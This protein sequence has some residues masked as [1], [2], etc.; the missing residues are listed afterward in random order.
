MQDD[1]LHVNSTKK[2]PKTTTSWCKMIHLMWTLQRRLPKQHTF[3][4]FDHLLHVNYIE[5]ATKVRPSRCKMIHF[6]WILLRKLHKSHLNIGWFIPCEPVE[7]V[8]KVTPSWWKTIHSTWILPK[9]IPKWYILGAG[10]L[11]HVNPSK[12]L[13]KQNF[14]KMM[15]SVWTLLRRLSKSHLLDARW[16]TQCELCQ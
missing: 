2:A 10:R 14:L 13:P 16:F 1:A 11:I 7:N 12:K 5:N 4:M 6:M 3:F 15:H 9:G 8:T